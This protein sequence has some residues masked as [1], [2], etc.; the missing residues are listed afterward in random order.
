M[1]P[2]SADPFDDWGKSRPTVSADRRVQS[3]VDAALAGVAAGVAVV[4]DELPESPLD[5]EEGDDDDDESVDG[6]VDD[7]DDD[8][9]LPP[10]L[11]VL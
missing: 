5:D 11:S 6:A 4:V 10:R 2:P 1:R 8:F 9:D 3:L 7:E